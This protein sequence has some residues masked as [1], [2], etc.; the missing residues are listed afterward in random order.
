[1]SAE[2]HQTRCVRRQVPQAD[3][4]GRSRVDDLER[5]V[6][7]DVSIQI[8]FAHLDKLHQRRSRDDLAD[9]G[10]HQRRVGGDGGLGRQVADAV[11]FTKNCTT[12]FDD[13]DREPRVARVADLAGDQRVQFRDGA[14]CGHTGQAEGAGDEAREGER[15]LLRAFNLRAFSVEAKLLEMQPLFSSS[16]FS[17]DAQDF[18]N[19]Y[20]CA[21]A[22]PREGV[23]P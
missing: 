16:I 5:Q 7:V 9:R 18:Q 17:S 21:A 4:A 23:L 14:R 6:T 20:R 11:A 3:C 8:D 2:I 10:D 19:Q 13:G 1:M 12:V 15:D 22:R